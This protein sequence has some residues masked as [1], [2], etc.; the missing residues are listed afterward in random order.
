[1]LQ[2][3]PDMDLAEKLEM[4][5]ALLGLSLEWYPKNFE[6]VSRLLGFVTHLLSEAYPSQKV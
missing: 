6:N 2:A 4:K 1:M 3:K 5:V